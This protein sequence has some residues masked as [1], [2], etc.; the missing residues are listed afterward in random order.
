METST[1]T[2]K[3]CGPERPRGLCELSPCSR[4]RAVTAVAQGNGGAVT[5]MK[6]S[7]WVVTGL[8]ATRPSRHFVII[9]TQGVGCVPESEDVVEVD[10]WLWHLVQMVFAFGLFLVK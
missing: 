2:Q 9:L 5:A 8:V 6:V 7:T 1:N 10:D 4:S 3:K